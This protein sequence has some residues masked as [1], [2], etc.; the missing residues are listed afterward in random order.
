MSCFSSFSN[1]REG[2]T[3][4]MQ[5]DGRIIKTHIRSLASSVNPVCSE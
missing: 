2:K 3:K 4:V 1:D 5:L